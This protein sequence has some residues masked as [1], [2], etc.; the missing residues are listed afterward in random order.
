[1]NLLSL[2]ILITLF[3]SLEARAEE[4]KIIIAPSNGY[5]FNLAE[6]AGQQTTCQVSQKKHRTVSVLSE[7]DKYFEVQFAE[8]LSGCWWE[9]SWRGMSIKSGFIRKDQ[10]TWQ[11]LNSKEIP[12]VVKSIP[13]K[14]IDP[15]AARR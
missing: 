1:M 13:G 6:M 7:T 4:R 12:A 5:W 9:L 10:I 14:R 8:P 15:R 11:E 3:C 2:L